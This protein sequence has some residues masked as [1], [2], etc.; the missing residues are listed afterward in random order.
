MP[1]FKLNHMR[2]GATESKIDQ[3]PDNKYEFL[4]ESYSRRQGKESE[5][6]SF[7]FRVLNH[8]TLSG[9]KYYDNFT[10]NESAIFKLEF[11]LKYAGGI[12]AD[13]EYD[14]D[15]DDFIRKALIGKTVKFK[16]WTMK[17]PDKSGKCRQVIIRDSWESVNL[18]NT[19]DSKTAKTT[20]SPV[21]MNDDSPFE[22]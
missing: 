12:P 22:D 18:P 13:A 4:V 21:F 15:D 9:K 16:I 14:T 19:P 11:L 5:Y 10:L 20:V 6:L 17:E 1:K 7:C 8:P 3:L 2:E